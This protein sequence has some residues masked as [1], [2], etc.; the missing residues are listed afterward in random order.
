[1]ARHP[2]SLRGIRD[3]ACINLAAKPGLQ[4]ILVC[5]F[6]DSLTVLGINGPTTTWLCGRLLRSSWSSFRFSFLLSSLSRLCAWVSK[7]HLPGSEAGFYVRLG[8]HFDSP[9][10][11]PLYH[12][13][14]PG[15][16]KLTYR[17]RTPAFTF[18]LVFIV[19]LLSHMRKAIGM[20]HGPSGLDIRTRLGKCRVLLIDGGLMIFGARRAGRSARPTALSDRL[21]TP[22]IRIGRSALV[23][24]QADKCVRFTSSERASGTA[25]RSPNACRGHGNRAKQDP[26]AEGG[27]PIHLG[28]RSSAR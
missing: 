8:L 17:F 14:A 27:G 2:T 25:L 23:Q 20:P 9:F 18:V 3:A 7:A 6:T 22:T 26:V 10:F 24:N 21:G 28:H 12:A 16:Q 11:C 13:S 15:R 4:T 19:L 1:L 5:H